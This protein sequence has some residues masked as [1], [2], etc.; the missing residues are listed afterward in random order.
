[1]PYH[2]LKRAGAAIPIRQLPVEAGDVDLSGKFVVWKDSKGVTCGGIV[3][4]DDSA[5]SM[6]E[7]HE[8]EG[9]TGTGVSWLPVWRWDNGE[10]ERTKQAPEGTQP[11][12]AEQCKKGILVVGELT[13]TYRLS[14]ETKQ[15]MQSLNLI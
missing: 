10:Y 9:N 11:M 14:P 2:S 1:M 15:R 6:V 4:K 12:I 3:V 13:S 8:Y 5:D 7:V